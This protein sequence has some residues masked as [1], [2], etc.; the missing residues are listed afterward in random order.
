M[1]ANARKEYAFLVVDPGVVPSRDN[2]VR[3]RRITITALGI[4]TGLLVG[5][6]YALIRSSRKGN[7]PEGNSVRGNA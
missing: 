1:M 3:P 2:Y 6:L 4:F 7:A 5:A